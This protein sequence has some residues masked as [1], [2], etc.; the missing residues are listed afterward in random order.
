[1]KLSTA[2]LPLFLV[3]C[4]TPTPAPRV[5]LASPSGLEHVELVALGLE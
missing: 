4:S 1:M 2:A 5:A 3:A